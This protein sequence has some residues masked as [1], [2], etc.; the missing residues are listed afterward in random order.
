MWYRLSVADRESGAETNW[1]VEGRDEN[2]AVHKAEAKGYLISSVETIPADKTH[3]GKIHTDER[4]PAVGAI[5]HYI[6]LDGASGVRIG[7]RSSRICGA[8]TTP[9]TRAFPTCACSKP[10]TT[11]S[12]L[13]ARLSW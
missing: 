2:E 8:R 10:R 9:F 3:G 6:L 1:D 11:I 7:R 5:V 13:R 12:L 4:E